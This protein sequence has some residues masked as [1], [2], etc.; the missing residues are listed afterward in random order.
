MTLRAPLL[1]GGGLR[2]DLVTGFFA[3]TF[4]VYPL[5]ALAET[6][7]HKSLSIFALKNPAKQREP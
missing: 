5:V 6:A 2:L 1:A 3:F 7:L 4:A